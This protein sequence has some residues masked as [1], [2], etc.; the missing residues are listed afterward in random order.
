MLQR[1]RPQALSQ[2]Q[3]HALQE[4]LAFAR[5]LMAQADESG[6]IDY[7]DRWG[8]KICLKC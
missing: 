4:A 7:Y 1:R 2:R 8:N 5:D 3:S 6:G